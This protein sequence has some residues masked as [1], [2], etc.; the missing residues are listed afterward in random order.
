MKISVDKEKCVKC[1]LCISDCVAKCLIKDEENYPILENEENCLNCKHC[2][3]ICPNGAINFEGQNLDNIEKPNFD[4]ILSIIKSRRSIRQFKNEEID[5]ETMEKLKDMFPYIPTGC[6][7]HKLHFSIVKNPSVMKEIK[8]FTNKKVLKLMNSVILSPFIK[9]FKIYKEAMENGEDIIYRNA[10]HMVIVS[11]PINA[12]C[13]DIDPVIA[14]SYF[15]LYANSLGIGTCFCGYAA[16]CMK[17]F[18]EL[19]IMLDIPKNYIPIYVMLFGKPSVKYQRIA[20]PEKYEIA[21]ISEIK[22]KKVCFLDKIKRFFINFL[23]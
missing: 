7:S 16:I 8:E 15:E 13:A 18:P 9:H 12:P 3:M 6:N 11:S 1:N 4:N 14:L 22:D 10:P 2:F 23:R 21:E 19:S 17:M 20:K 5:D